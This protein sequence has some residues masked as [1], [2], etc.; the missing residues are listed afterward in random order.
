PKS[1]SVTLA[2]AAAKHALH[3]QPVQAVPAPL[4]DK[5]GKANKLLGHGKGYLYAHDFPENI[6]PQA[7]LEKPLHLFTPKTAGIEAKL[8]ER[9]ARWRALRAASL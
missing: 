9:L 6:A 2:L 4:R 3:T 7:Y 8:A 5:G 1:N